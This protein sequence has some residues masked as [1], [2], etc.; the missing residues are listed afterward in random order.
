M[1][2]IAD[3]VNAL[4]QK[5]PAWQTLKDIELA[6]ADGQID[7][8]V[9]NFSVVTRVRHE[10]VDKILKCYTR[11][12]PHLKEIYGA[13]FLPKELVIT[14]L[15]GATHLIDCLLT[16]Y[17]AG[18]TLDEHLHNKDCNIGALADAFERL[19]QRLLAENLAHGDI[20]PDNIIVG[21]DG[22]LHLID[23][24]ACFIERLAGM[25]SAELGSSAYQHPARSTKH[26][27]RHIDD[28]SIAY[29]LTML[30]AAQIDA[31]VIEHYRSFFAFAPSP[32]D[33]VN[34]AGGAIAPLTERF[35]QL[36][37]AK[38]YRL[39]KMLSSPTPSLY[40]LEAILTPT[41]SLD[42]GASELEQINGYWGI[43]NSQCW[44]V[45][46]LY[47][48]ILEPFGDI[49]IAGIDDYITIN[50]LRHGM[51]HTLAKGCHITQPDNEGCRIEQPSGEESYI[52]YSDL[53]HN[54]AK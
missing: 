46:P 38:E 10:G 33:I 49:Y 22:E 50:S 18:K 43:T 24:D 28:Y 15:M 31:S 12:R 52:K 7:Y 1:Y 11:H 48:W 8:A 26:Y 4:R 40:G 23:W 17:I 6:R 2:A 42:D 16:D 51:L 25:E 34:S 30:R 27:N 32:A 35:A 44:V 45:G 29:L 54:F 14:D 19:A 53:L 47:D 37:M 9:G 21:E 39:S 36:G 5:W 3:I 41:Q 13:H 20:K